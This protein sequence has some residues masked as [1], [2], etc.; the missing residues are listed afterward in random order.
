MKKCSNNI[1]Q[2]SANLTNNVKT[3]I[4]LFIAVQ[5][6]V[7]L[8]IPC[9]FTSENS[10]MLKERDKMLG[11]ILAQIGPQDASEVLPSSSMISIL[12]LALWVSSLKFH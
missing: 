6:D 11:T 8:P 9:Y 3:Y 12:L 2:K 4:L 7:E 10:K 1:V 5:A